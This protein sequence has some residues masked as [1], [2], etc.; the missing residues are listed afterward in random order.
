ML[1]GGGKKSRRPL[2]EVEALILEEVAGVM[3]V[4]LED[5]VMVLEEMAEV[6]TVV[7]REWDVKQLGRRY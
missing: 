4:V 1:E 2:S 3:V 7:P 5:L 6:M